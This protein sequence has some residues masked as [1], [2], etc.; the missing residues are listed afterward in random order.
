MKVY[1]VPPEHIPT[2]I[3]LAS[4]IGA[5][6]TTLTFAALDMA[7]FP[8]ARDVVLSDE[9]DYIISAQARAVEYIEAAGA[10]EEL[11]DRALSA[12]AL[13]NYSGNVIPHEV[14]NDGVA[15][16]GRYRGLPRASFRI[17]VMNSR[18]PGAKINRMT[19]RHIKAACW[20]AHF[21]VLAVLFTL[22]P[23][24]VIESAFDVYRGLADFRNRAP[25][26]RYQNIGSMMNPVEARD[27]CACEAD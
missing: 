11:R 7:G 6:E 22:Y 23:E 5:R 12:G 14:E 21:D 19:G 24:A 15:I 16:R 26:T 18:G 1:G 8:Y 17:T 20:H 2:I 27:G 10:T 3:A 4:V 13:L 9:T 25:E